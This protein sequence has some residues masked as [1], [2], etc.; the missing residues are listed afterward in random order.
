MLFNK[1]KEKAND[2]KNQ[3]TVTIEEFRELAESAKDLIKSCENFIQK[4]TTPPE[5]IKK[6]PEQLQASEELRK[7]C[8][9]LKEL[10]NLFQKAISELVAPE[11]TLEQLDEILLD[12]NKTEEE[13]NLNRQKFTSGK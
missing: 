10:N 5:I 3:P 2:R 1:K 11:A 7:R 6:N 4:S 8:M 13:L 9:E 12:M